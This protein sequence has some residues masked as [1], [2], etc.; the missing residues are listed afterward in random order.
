M[1]NVITREAGVE[2]ERTEYVTW[3]TLKMKEGKTNQR[4]QETPRSYERQGDRFS[5]TVSRGIWPCKLHDFNQR[6]QFHISDVHGN[7]FVLL[8]VAKFVALCCSSNRKL[9]QTL[10]PGSGCF[11]V[12]T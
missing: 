8:Y 3:L 5:P 6:E 10:I 1:S 7:K 4:I 9:I 2:S 12:N 11:Y